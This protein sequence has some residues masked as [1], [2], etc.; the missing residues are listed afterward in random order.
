VQQIT[1]PLMKA[2]PDAIAQAA[3]ALRRGELV[4]LPTE[5]VYGLG[6][7]ATNARA[8]ARIYEAKGR[9]RFNP[10]IVHVASAEQ[11]AAIAVLG[12][13]AV[14][15]AEAFWPGPLTLVLPLRQDSG[16]ADLVTAGLDTV[17]VRVPSHPVALDL[18]AAAGCPIA[19]PSANRS[20]HVSPT[21]AQHVEDDLGDAP[22]II[23][24]AGR[25]AHGLEST[26]VDASGDFLVLL[27]AGA[28]TAEAIEQVLGER[29]IRN[30]DTVA[31]GSAALPSAPGQLASHYAPRAPLRLE[32]REVGAGEALLAFGADVPAHGGPAINLSP[33]GDLVEAAANLFAALRQLDAARPAAIAV[34]PI[35]DRGL[36]EAINDRLRRGAAPR[37]GTQQ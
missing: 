37:S 12:P 33:T 29:L 15:L 8:V 6:A 23:L 19:A 32:A 31:D 36:G 9:P 27:R 35:P 4:A 14:R 16:I 5:T 7:D 21:T 24:D 17:A 30:A 3:A 18:I 20:G 22:A 2:T 25:T 26:I 1:M 28:V 11:A 13:K 10:L 34:M